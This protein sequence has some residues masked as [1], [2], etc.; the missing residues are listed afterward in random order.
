MPIIDKTK[1]E[2]GNG[3]QILSAKKPLQSELE[4]NKNT[5]PFSWDQVTFKRKGCAIQFKPKTN[6]D[7]TEE[8]VEHEIVFFK[9]WPLNHPV[10]NGYLKNK[11]NYTKWVK[12]F[13]GII[14]L[15]CLLI[16]VALYY[17]FIDN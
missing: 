12:I 3:Y 14:G 16:L 15:I 10:G 8:R 2:E 11:K 1:E 13:F 6:T 7:N 4:L 9:R 5:T 17:T